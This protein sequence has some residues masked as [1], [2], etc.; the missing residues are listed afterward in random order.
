V[1]EGIIK[2]ENEI[3][4]MREAGSILAG[5]LDQL[6]NLIKPDLDVWELEELFLK[7][8]KENSVEPS[9]KGYESYGLSP[10]PTGLCTSI[11][12]QC[13]HCFPKKGVILKEGDIIS[14]DTVI[15]HKGLHVDSAFACGVG[16]ISDEK[17]R[18][19]LEYKP[20]N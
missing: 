7:L 10:F 9:C 20:N 16:K 13:V 6:K 18:L 12:N 17:K 5:I 15:K 8:C 2:S 3:E 11:N 1:D 4:I 14:V 19:I